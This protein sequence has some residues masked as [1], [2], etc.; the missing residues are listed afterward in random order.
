MV[1]VHDNLGV[2]FSIRN[3][4]QY[5]LVWRESVGLEFHFHTEAISHFAAINSVA[6]RS[7]VDFGMSW[8]GHPN[9]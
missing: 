5:F 4:F 3:R 2:I 1:H 6:I 9:S 7:P 8:S